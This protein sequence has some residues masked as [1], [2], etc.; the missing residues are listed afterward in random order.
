MA[1]HE[2]WCPLA[3]KMGIII[4]IMTKKYDKTHK[5]K[6]FVSMMKYNC[7]TLKGINV[8][9]CCLLVHVWSFWLN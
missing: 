2:L 6:T 9:I 4:Y 8:M 1:I 5:C 3:I 7:D